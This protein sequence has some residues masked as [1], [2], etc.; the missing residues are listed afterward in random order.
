MV[1]F[2]EV[3]LFIAMLSVFLLGCGKSKC[4]ELVLKKQENATVSEAWWNE[5][6]SGVNSNSGIFTPL[7][8]DGR[9]LI[10]A[11]KDV[12]VWFYNDCLYI[13]FKKRGKA[14]KLPQ[15]F[16]YDLP[17]DAAIEAK[18]ILEEDVDSFDDFQQKL[19]KRNS[20]KD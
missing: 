15:N 16:I 2:I 12:H 18:Y 9:L 10:V 17:N 11:K 8:K 6:T 7:Y 13:A 19:K 5:M 14:Y 20:I 3:V 1:R 4:I